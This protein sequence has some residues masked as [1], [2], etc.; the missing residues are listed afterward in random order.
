[1]TGPPPPAADDPYP[2]ELHER[3]MQ[4]LRP[5]LERRRQE[6]ALLRELWEAGPPKE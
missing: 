1:M 6:I 4:A 2:L 5:G 3:I